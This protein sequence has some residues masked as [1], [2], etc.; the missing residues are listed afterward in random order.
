MFSNVTVE[1]SYWLK[2]FTLKEVRK[3]F[4]HDQ[5]HIISIQIKNQ[6]TT[7]PINYNE[8]LSLDNI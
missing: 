5:V 6:N 3:Q 7:G 4:P 1:H 2:F 8:I